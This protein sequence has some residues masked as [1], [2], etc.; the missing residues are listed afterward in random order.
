M[1]LLPSKE[2]NKQNSSFLSK[3][4]NS[5]SQMQ[6]CVTH[7]RAPAFE[8]ITGPQ[9]HYWRHGTDDTALHAPAAAPKDALSLFLPFLGRH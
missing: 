7:V 1:V 8:I 9:N 5:P 3:Q 6:Y 4:N 2:M